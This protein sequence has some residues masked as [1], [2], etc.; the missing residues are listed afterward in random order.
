MTRETTTQTN[1]RELVRAAPKCQL[2]WTIDSETGKPVARWT[3][4]QPEMVAGV[5]LRSAA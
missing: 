3:V 2:K 1:T 4:E 5:A